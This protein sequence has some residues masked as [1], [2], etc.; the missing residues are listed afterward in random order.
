MSAHPSGVLTPL[1]PP[2][3][4][5]AEHHD[6]SPRFIR[7]EH[8]DWRGVR[9]RI[10]YEENYLDGFLSH[11]SLHVLEPFAAP[12]PVTETGYRSHFVDHGSVEACG[13][14]AAFVQAWLDH[15]APSEE[16]SVKE[17]ESRQMSLF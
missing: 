9:L 12:L 8:A 16:W 6:G 10:E 2:E 1:P 14:P 5:Q 4:I 15:E 13:G 11:L 7:H 3:L 17:I